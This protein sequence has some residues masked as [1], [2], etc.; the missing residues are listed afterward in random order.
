MVILDTSVFIAFFNDADS[1]NQKADDVFMDLKLRDIYLP[2]LVY[3]EILTIIK[4]KTPNPQEVF[5]YL[6]TFLESVGLEVKRTDASILH[7]A[8]EN[9]INIPGK[10]SFVDMVLLAYAQNGHEVIT[11]DRE[12][13]GL[14][15]ARR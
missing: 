8:E 13:N 7:A 15:E 10:I 4:I 3:Y 1:Q 14:L 9:L 12:L 5:S 6:Q 11:F 2:E